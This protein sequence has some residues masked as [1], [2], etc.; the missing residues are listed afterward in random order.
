MGGKKRVLGG[1][2]RESGEEGK[3][4][5][6]TGEERVSGEVSFENE[7]KKETSLRSPSST[8]NWIAQLNL[9]HF[10][11]LFIFT[12]LQFSRLGFLFSL[13]VLVFS[14]LIS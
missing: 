2:K 13:S 12:V 4:R 9:V 10:S 6:R 7:K 5:R 1:R 14:G 11:S 8:F 3:P